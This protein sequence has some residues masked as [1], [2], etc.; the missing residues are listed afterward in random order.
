MG[1]YE[2]SESIIEMSESNYWNVRIIIEM[3][4]S[5]IEMSES[6]IE[7]SESIIE[8][9]FIEMLE[10]IIEMLESRE[11]LKKNKKNN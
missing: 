1:W 6:I 4:E 8:E 10:S 2:L 3:S 5:F 11:G 9:S 7:M